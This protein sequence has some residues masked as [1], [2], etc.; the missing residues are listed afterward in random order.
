MNKG[1]DQEELFRKGKEITKN[2]TLLQEL[3]KRN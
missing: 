1:K 2:K 3:N